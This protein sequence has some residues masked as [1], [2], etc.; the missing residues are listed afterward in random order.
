MATLRASAIITV[1]G[2]IINLSLAVNGI[3]ITTGEIETTQGKAT[4]AINNIDNES[5]G[6]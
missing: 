2:H 1:R 5:L 4:I 6:D 3:L